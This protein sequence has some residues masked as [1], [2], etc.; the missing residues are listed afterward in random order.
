VEQTESNRAVTVFLPP[1]P[2]V[3]AA[4][5]SRGSR[6]FAMLKAPVCGLTGAKAGELSIKPTMGPSAADTWG[7]H[8]AL[9]MLPIVFAATSV[10]AYV[11]KTQAPLCSRNVPTWHVRI[12]LWGA[13][14][15]AVFTSLRSIIGYSIPPPRQV[16]RFWNV[17]FVF[18]QLLGVMPYNWALMTC[19]TYTWVRGRWLRAV[20]PVLYS[21]LALSYWFWSQNGG[22]QMW[23]IIMLF[24]PR[25]VIWGIIIFR[26]QSPNVS[27]FERRMLDT[28]IWGATLI[29]LLSSG[30]AL[31]Y[32]T[33]PH[34][35]P[36]HIVDMICLQ[37]ITFTLLCAVIRVDEDLGLQPVAT[38]RSTRQQGSRSGYSLKVLV[39]GDASSDDA[40][41]ASSLAT[42]LQGT[43]GGAID[44]RDLRILSLI[45]KGGQGEIYRGKFGSTM[46]A[47][48]AVEGPGPGKDSPG[49]PQE[50]ELLRSL[51]H[52]NIIRFFGKRRVQIIRSRE[53]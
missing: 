52:P 7:L 11:K 40:S 6:V 41:L 45:A 25:W 9:P 13:A 34:A 10:L 22:S 1:H 49:L 42:M 29:V 39:W 5:Y 17:L 12:L 16:Q 37:L 50:A 38:S 32:I 23:L 33:Y 36:L 3:T 30:G 24:F 27:P 46:V 2:Y 18:Y 51:Q 35:T 53:G 19:S 44:F 28:L 14:F 21:S 43:S 48:K 4:E 20:V 26:Y 31:G 47:I 15:A 8:F